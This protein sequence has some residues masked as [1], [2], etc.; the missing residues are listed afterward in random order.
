V[1]LFACASAESQEAAPNAP[2]LALPSDT[3]YIVQPDDVLQITVYEEPSLTTKVR[4]TRAGD[5]NFPL[6]GRVDVNGLSVDQIEHRLTELLEKDYLVN[7][8]VNIF[9]ESY[10]PRY[11]FVTGAV[12]KPGSYPIL[13]GQR[14]TVMEAI[15]MAGG[16]TEE[17][18]LNNTRIIRT[19]AND[20]KTIKVHVKDI[21]EKGDKS[22]DEEVYANDVIFVPESFF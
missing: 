20:E 7:P 10:H 15:T 17:A 6:L 14:T 4:V 1:S 5:F 3:E 12:T 16:F 22:K 9:I 13:P 8:Q 18:S 2:V 11:V 21:I 19:M